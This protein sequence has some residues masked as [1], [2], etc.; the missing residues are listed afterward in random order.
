MI[1]LLILYH[2]FDQV[3]KLFDFVLKQ[4]VYIFRT[5]FNNIMHVNITYKVIV[6]IVV[7]QQEKYVVYKFNGM[8][9]HWT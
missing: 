5:I 8:S 1:A 3:N 7:S 9:T 4:K 2:Y 6:I